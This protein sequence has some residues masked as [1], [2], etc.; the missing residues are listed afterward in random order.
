[1]S[2]APA[3]KRGRGRPKSVTNPVRARKGLPNEV[4]HPEYVSGLSG[5]KRK[6][7]RD[8]ALKWRRNNVHKLSD[9]A[10]RKIAAVL[11]GSIT[12]PDTQ[13]SGNAH[14]YEHSPLEDSE[15]KRRKFPEYPV[16]ENGV[17]EI[18]AN[19]GRIRKNK[20]IDNPKLTIKTKVHNLP[21]VAK[22]AS[23]ERKQV[24]VAAEVAKQGKKRGRKGVGLKGGVVQKRKRVRVAR[25]GPLV[26]SDRAADEL[27]PASAHID[28]DWLKGTD[29][30]VPP[31]FIDMSWLNQPAAK[32]SN[33]RAREIP[34]QK[35][36]VR[37]VKRRVA[38]PEKIAPPKPKKVKP[39]AD[40][41]LGTFEEL[42]RYKGKTI[43]EI[44]AIKKAEGKRQYEE[45]S[46][47]VAQ[48][49][50]VKRKSEAVVGETKRRK[51]QSILPYKPAAKGRKRKGS[52]ELEGQP[53]I[54]RRKLNPITGT[55]P[56]R[57]DDD[58]GEGPEPKRP[59]GP[60]P[61]GTK[62]KRE[63]AGDES[64]SKRSRPNPPSRKR[65]RDED[66]ENHESKR[67]RVDADVYELGERLRNGSELSQD[68]SRR[69]A[70]H[71]QQLTTHYISAR[72]GTKRTREEDP[73]Q[74]TQQSK[75]V[76]L[77]GDLPIRTVVP[78]RVELLKH[79]SEMTSVELEHAVL[80]EYID[81]SIKDEIRQLL[82][83]KVKQEALGHGADSI[84]LLN[85]PIDRVNPVAEPIN[86]E[87]STHV[88][89][90]E[91]L[92]S[93]E[94][95]FETG[96]YHE[97]IANPIERNI[98]NAQQY[99]ADGVPSIAVSTKGKR[100]REAADNAQE[101]QFERVVKRKFTDIGVYNLNNAA[102]D[103]TLQNGSNQG[104]FRRDD[105]LAEYNDGDDTYMLDLFKR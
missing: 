40:Q 76:R 47:P 100:T 93:L 30:T 65:A 58:G 5:N 52:D 46:V 89:S 55:K 1:M 105:S 101:K 17:T 59:R 66:G 71:I 64:G 74:D 62:R 83:K 31:G 34:E 53:P 80:N 99:Y 42:N 67:Q 102:P 16:Q 24:F 54:K 68:E 2:T 77:D 73:G 60:P 56:K 36:E 39:T 22:V 48:R 8:T 3:V 37:D 6:V 88:P 15:H 32:K 18:Y 61:S 4:Y 44:V 38:P 9:A 51:A 20:K 41:L 82:K 33:K 27:P 29:Q 69:L 85:N 104:G 86:A 12:D 57:G 14:V 45:G 26:E 28:L 84:E 95:K 92:E 11:S 23:A 97:E 75:R 91:Q 90:V 35:Y 50:G 19:L 81:P 13:L 98:R 21:V 25:K 72:R 94:K 96:Y 43:P 63:D 70:D 7:D 103:L 78:N 79:Y 49:R 87:V 10:K